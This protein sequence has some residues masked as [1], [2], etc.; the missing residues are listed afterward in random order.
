[1]KVIPGRLYNTRRNLTPAERSKTLVELASA[2]KTRLSRDASAQSGQGLEEFRSS[3]ERNLPGGRPSKPDSQKR[4]AEEMGMAVGTLNEAQRHVAAVERYPELGTGD[5]PRAEVL[6]LAAEWDAIPSQR[7]RTFAR[8]A[9]A[10]THVS[11][12]TPAP[13]AAAP[14]R[15]RGRRR[16]AVSHPPTRQ[17]PH[18]A[19]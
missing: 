9:W 10:K 19:L 13:A 2:I 4:I 18:D 12:D 1:V 7:K 15:S 17:G 11:R 14:T 16:T 5:L 3:D 8:K 6:Q